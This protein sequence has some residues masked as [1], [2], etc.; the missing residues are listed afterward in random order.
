MSKTGQKRV[1][2]SLSGAIALGSNLS[3]AETSSADM[4]EQAIR[5]LDV[6]ELVI[7]QTSRFFRTPAFPFGSGPD[8][9]NACVSFE[10]NLEPKAVL[11][12]LHHVEA[13]FGRQREVRWA[14]RTL[15]LDLLF[16]GDTVLPDR[17]TLEHWMSLPAELQS[18]T[19]PQ[20]LLLPHPRLHERAFVLIPLED[21]AADW[22]HPVTGQSVRHMRQA[23][24]SYLTEEVVPL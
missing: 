6:G 5:N 10:T 11:E 20:D 3:S 22:C 9:V 17:A 19:V 14:P 7:R 8:F 23:L 18:Q 16:L 12:R 2:F 13:S 24:P 1:H 21:V 15:D 4:V